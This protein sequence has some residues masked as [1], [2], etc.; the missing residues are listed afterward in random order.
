LSHP[1]YHALSAARHFGGEWRDYVEVE[2]W[3][4]QTKGHI[5]D[6]RHRLL[7]HNDF[8]VELCGK[9]F[10]ETLLRPSDGK[11]VAVS[12]VARRHVEEDFG[13]QVP[14]VEE[15]F[16]RA[17][18]EP[19]MQEARGFPTDALAARRFGGVPA[20]YREIRRWFERAEGLC[21]DGRARLLLTHTF[22]IF[23][24]EQR[25]GAV[26]TRASDGVPVPTR[27]V[28]EAYVL[29]VF[30]GRI[31]TASNLLEKVPLEAWMGARARPLSR[32]LGAP[33]R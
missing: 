30:R 13:G 17:P 16:R 25:F 21:P 5:A 31:P 3:L 6:A 14:A 33:L 11:H 19:W 2:R 29:R 20:D 4:D 9:V 7:L 15:C 18:L 10:G 32:E 8:G 23:L 12:E 26:L 22:G 28:A 1:Y 27:P 24:C